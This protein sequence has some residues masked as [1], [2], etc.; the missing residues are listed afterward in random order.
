MGLHYDLPVYKACYDLL[1]EIFQFTKDFSRE[2]KYTFGESLIN[3]KKLRWVTRNIKNWAEGTK[4]EDLTLIKQRSKL[5]NWCSKTP[6]F[7][8]CHPSDCLITHTYLLITKQTQYESH[9][10]FQYL[11]L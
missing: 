5:K 6:N 8:Y 2:Y 3:G 9:M 11:Y 4:Y 1:L 10:S 7:S